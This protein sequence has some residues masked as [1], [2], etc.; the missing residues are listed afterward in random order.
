MFKKCFKL[1]WHL[2]PSTHK[3]K[4]H[5]HWFAKSKNFSM[6][7]QEDGKVRNSIDSY[8][9]T[10]FSASLI[11]NHGQGIEQTRMNVQQ[12]LLES[13]IRRVYI[14]FAEI[15]KPCGARKMK[16]AIE[17]AIETD[18]T[19]IKTHIAGHINRTKIA[20]NEWAREGRVA[21][22]TLRAL[23]ADSKE[24]PRCRAELL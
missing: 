12:N 10:G 11:E 14:S 3:L 9:R 1:Q 17:L 22:Q 21:L 8:I 23:V 20:R 15:A 16:I 5:S 18:L 2:L 24:S 19:G 6:F 13:R 4:H 7:L